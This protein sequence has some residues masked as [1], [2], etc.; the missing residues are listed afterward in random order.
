MRTDL[1]KGTAIRVPSARSIHDQL[2][3]ERLERE[4]RLRDRDEAL[5]NRIEAALG[6]AA[7]GVS[8]F[9]RPNQ[10]G[11]GPSPAPI[12]DRQAA[13]AA[14]DEYDRLRHENHDERVDAAARDQAAAVARADRAFLD[15]DRE[16]YQI[17]DADY[18]YFD[19]HAREID[20]GAALARQA[21]DDRRRERTANREERNEA[22]RRYTHWLLFE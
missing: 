12:V 22:G 15:H 21:A 5:R 17:T 14:A 16:V 10:A 9:A 20:D 4:N 8:L 6:A 2:V 7:R 19:R 11:T 1:P 3:R 18:D 13:D